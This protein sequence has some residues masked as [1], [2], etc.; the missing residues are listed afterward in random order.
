VK[1]ADLIG[2]DTGHLRGMPTSPHSRGTGL[3][4]RPQS[5]VE[6]DRAIEYVNG[7][8]I[9]YVSRI[10]KCMYLLQSLHNIHNFGSLD[11]D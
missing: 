7:Y 6:L 4:N 2:R 10:I 9:K 1:L 5:E 8:I 3:S 11:H